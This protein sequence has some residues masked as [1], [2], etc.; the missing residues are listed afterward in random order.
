MSVYDDY[1]SAQ[2]IVERIETE[3]I[4]PMT[5]CAL[6]IGRTKGYV[7]KMMYPSMVYL[8]YK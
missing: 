3:W 5:S 6:A 4:D 2:S 8:V 7:Y 1:A